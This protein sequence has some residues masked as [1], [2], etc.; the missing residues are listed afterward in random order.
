MIRQ[1]LTATAT[2]RPSAELLTA[3]SRSLATYA[4][5]SFPSPWSGASRSTYA[6]DSLCSASSSSAP[7]KP[8]ISSP[9]QYQTKQTNPPTQRLHLL[10]HPHRR[11]HQLRHYGPHLHAR[12]RRLLDLHGN[13]L[14]RHLRQ[15]T[16]APP[17]LRALLSHPRQHHLH[18]DG[19]VA[20]LQGLLA[21]RD[22]ESVE[23]CAQQG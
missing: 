21:Q 20:A 13:G 2:T 5:S 12:I 11:S 4:S 10:R 18:Q 6:A 7:C 22:G 9:P 15:P 16:A 17:L 19:L 3:P 23:Y 14:R 1:S 8:P